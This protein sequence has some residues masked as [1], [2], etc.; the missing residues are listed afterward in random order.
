MAADEP[1]GQ[2]VPVNEIACIVDH[3]SV[4]PSLSGDKVN[5]TITVTLELDAAPALDMVMKIIGTIA[6]GQGLGL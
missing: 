6:R 1:D 3:L 5:L 4:A 2:S